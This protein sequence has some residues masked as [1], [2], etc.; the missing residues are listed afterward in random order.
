MIGQNI[1]KSSSQGEQRS[2][3]PRIQLT[4]K[5]K[6]KLSI[7]IETRLKTYM[8]SETWKTCRVDKPVEPRGEKGI[9]RVRQV[10]MIFV[11]KHFINLN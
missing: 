2:R 4:N 3:P 1:F 10:E 9:Q 7:N 6:N 8:I 11:F 5:L